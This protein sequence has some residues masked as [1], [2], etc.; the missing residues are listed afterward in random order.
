MCIDAPSEDGIN[1]C[2]GDGSYACVANTIDNVEPFNDLRRKINF[3]AIPITYLGHIFI[4][5]EFISTN[6]HS[7]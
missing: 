5:H 6:K 3:L 1:Q 7:Q 2:M 4:K